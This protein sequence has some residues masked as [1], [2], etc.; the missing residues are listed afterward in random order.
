[1]TVHLRA[2]SGSTCY[3]LLFAFWSAEC[4]FGY[5]YIILLLNKDAENL[6]ETKM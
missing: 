6:S 2:C 4:Y 5:V 1:M 3:I